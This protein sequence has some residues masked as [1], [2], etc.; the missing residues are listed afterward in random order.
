MVLGTNPHTKTPMAVR[1]R[2]GNRTPKHNNESVR[3]ASLKDATKN[4]IHTP[5]LPPEL[6]CIE[7]LLVTAE[8]LPSLTVM[9]PAEQTPTSNHMV[10]I[11][12]TSGF[13]PKGGLWTSRSCEISG[14]RWARWCRDNDFNPSGNTRFS[15]WETQPNSEAVVLRVE[16]E[17]DA[18]RV[19]EHFR[20]TDTQPL[21]ELLQMSPLDY[22]KLEQLGVD[23]I[24]VS[25]EVSHQMQFS[26]S[27]DF[28]PF[29]GWDIETTLW[30]NNTSISSFVKRHDITIETE[31]DTIVWGEH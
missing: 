17:E 30:L 18:L 13:K 12:N 9:L 21:A 14:S 20:I 19:A 8:D 1:R 26:E 5:V 28:S 22:E 25:E 6:T 2:V 23:A 3:S 27:E 24:W 7:D 4:L 15:L 16:T 31:I 11:S 10:K 29:C